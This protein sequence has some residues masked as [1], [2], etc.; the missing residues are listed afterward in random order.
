MQLVLM[1]IYLYTKQTNKKERTNICRPTGITRKATD[2]TRRRPT[3]I[4]TDRRRETDREETDR[5][6]VT[7]TDRQRN[8]ES[9][10]EMDKDKDRAF[11]SN[12][13]GTNSDLPMF[14]QLL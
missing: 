14:L 7:E 9:E 11:I 10:T 3:E 4:Q 12:F 5:Q 13:T 1:T 8:T 6:T 2:T